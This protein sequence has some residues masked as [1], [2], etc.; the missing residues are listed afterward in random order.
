MLAV[1]LCVT[2]VLAC[3]T[4]VLEKTHFYHITLYFSLRRGRYEQ[5]KLLVTVALKYSLNHTIQPPHV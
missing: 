5:Q 4:P 2:T 3:P 1:V